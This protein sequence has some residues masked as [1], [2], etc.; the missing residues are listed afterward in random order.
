MNGLP[1]LI[2]ACQTAAGPAVREARSI[3]AE[4]V[5]WTTSGSY[6]FLGA[7]KVRKGKN[8]KKEKIVGNLP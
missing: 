5:L 3:A 2:L 4:G 6:G 7:Q 1:F 8:L